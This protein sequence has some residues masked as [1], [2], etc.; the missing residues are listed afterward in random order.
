MSIFFHIC[1]NKLRFISHLLIS[2]QFNPLPHFI[3]QKF[4]LFR[5]ILRFFF[6]KNSLLA[7]ILLAIFFFFDDFLFFSFKIIHILL[8]FLQKLLFFFYTLT[9]QLGLFMLCLS[10]PNYY[11]IIRLLFLVYL[12]LYLLKRSHSNIIPLLYLNQCTLIISK[13]SI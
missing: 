13:K 3:F 5:Q 6:L 11:T 9:Y 4:F 2:L 8:L 12:L 10:Q 1:L 7:Q